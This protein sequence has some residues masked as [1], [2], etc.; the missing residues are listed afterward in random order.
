MENGIRG[1]IGQR[2]FDS[3]RLMSGSEPGIVVGM[4]IDYRICMMK[5]CC[6][7]DN[8]K[9]VAPLVAVILSG[10]VSQN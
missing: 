4:K 2:L 6:C 10:T 3:K 8:P 9:F 7:Q 1:E 5:K